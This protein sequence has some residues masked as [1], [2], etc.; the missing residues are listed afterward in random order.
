MSV[1]EHILQVIYLIDGIQTVIPTK[2]IYNQSNENELQDIHFEI[3]FE[4]NKIISKKSCNT[5]E[6]I[7]NL[8]RV[9]PQN[10]NIA[11]C[12]SCIY[13]N[14]CPFGDCD[15][16]VFCL[17]DMTPNNKNDVSDFFLRN[18][19]S[20][21]GKSRKLLD[22]CTDYKPISDKECYTYNDWKIKSKSV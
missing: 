15:N 17:K 12:Q 8:Q 4:K 14:F 16:E 2:V 21:N 7:I 9:L 20:L 19:D 22:Y 1:K 6:A 10:I 11:C 3:H 18:Q 13:G 5:E